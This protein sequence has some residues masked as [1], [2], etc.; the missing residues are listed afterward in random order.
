MENV[1]TNE[2]VRRM[3][4]L[5][6]SEANGISEIEQRKQKEAIDDGKSKVEYGCGLPIS[7][8]S[9]RSTQRLRKR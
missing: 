9:C 7:Y 5:K 3:S 2:L 6:C 4:D 8:Q 1:R